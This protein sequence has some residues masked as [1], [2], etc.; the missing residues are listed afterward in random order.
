[1][2][3]DPPIRGRRHTHTHPCSTPR[4]RGR[5]ECAART[6]DDCPDD[7]T[8]IVCEDCRATQDEEEMTMATQLVR[9]DCCGAEDEFLIANAH[10]GRRVRVEGTCP[11]CGDKE[12]LGVI[13]HRQE[14]GIANG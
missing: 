10:G 4:C 9:V 5:V 1:M 12:P 6:D 8:W 7:E 13:V 2:L 11:I 3:I 14:G